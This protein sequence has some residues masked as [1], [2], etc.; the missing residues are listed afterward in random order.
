MYGD[1]SIL[2]IKMKD[3]CARGTRDTV[4]AFIEKAT[5]ELSKGSFESLM[6]GAKLDRMNE[7]NAIK[8]ISFGKKP[9]LK[10]YE[11]PKCDEP[12]SESDSTMDLLINEGDPILVAAQREDVEGLKIVLFLAEKGAKATVSDSDTGK[13][14]MHH[15]V[16]LVCKNREAIKFYKED[17]IALFGFAEKS[18][19]PIDLNIKNNYGCTPAMVAKYKHC[20][21][22]VS[23]LDSYSKKPVEAPKSIVSAVVSTSFAT[24]THPFRPKASAGLVKEWE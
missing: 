15:I 24:M 8:H 9:L 21:E 6:V 18:G 4:A 2:F 11:K 14:V 23:F 16:E 7:K 12:D 19:H 20:P 3:E 13:G 1:R 17:I 5:K 10:G 22:L